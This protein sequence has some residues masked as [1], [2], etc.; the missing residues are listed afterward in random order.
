[1]QDCEVSI[2]AETI[3][4][5]VHA[6][7]TFVPQVGEMKTHPISP[8]SERSPRLVDLLASCHRHGRIISKAVS[9]STN[10]LDTA[11]IVEAHG[12]ICEGRSVIDS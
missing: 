6:L 9:P 1:M 10:P 5:T 4:E 12:C 3:S 8:R 7:L 11:L 2:S